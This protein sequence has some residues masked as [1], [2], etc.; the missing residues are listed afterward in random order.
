MLAGRGRR[1]KR[2]TD[3]ADTERVN[4]A[5]IYGS[6]V[7]AVGGFATWLRAMLDAEREER[8]REVFTGATVLVDRRTQLGTVGRAMPDALPVARAGSFCRVVGSVGITGRGQQLVC[9]DV[10]GSRPRWRRVAERRSA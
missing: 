2:V 8:R 4:E 10:A 6:F 1:F 3:G 5:V 9:T 7:L